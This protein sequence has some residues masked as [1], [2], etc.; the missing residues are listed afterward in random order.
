[1]LVAFVLSYVLIL[2]RKSNFSHLLGVT[3][4]GCKRKIEVFPFHQPRGLCLLRF[5]PFI[6]LEAGAC[7]I[8]EYLWMVGFL[9]FCRIL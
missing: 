3:C 5:F 6:Y 7:Q 9:D 4:K 2:Q 8:F 1:M